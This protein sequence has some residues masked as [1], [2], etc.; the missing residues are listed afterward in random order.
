M[1]NAIIRL[2]LN[3]RMLVAAMAALVLVLGGLAIKNLPVDVFPDLN[4]P[5]VTIMTEAPGMAP[6]EVEN[7]ISLPLETNLNGLPG[8]E[9][10]RS[11][12][13]IG[14]GVVYVE[15]AWGTDIYR[16]RQLV[17]E[18]IS[19]VQERMPAGI[20]PV[21]APVSSIMGQIM[22]IAVAAKPDTLTPTE[23]RTLADWQLRPRLMAIPG[24][25][26]VI[27]IG[28]GVRQYQIQLDGTA[29]QRYQLNPDDVAEGL[30][31]LARNTTGGFVNAGGKEQLVRNMS[32]AASS[33][34][35]ENT[36]VGLHLGQPVLL[37]Q[38]AL[39][40]ET[41]RVKRGDG[42]FNG[43]PAVIMT[44][45]KQPGADT[46]ALT[47]A[48][49][50]AV[51]E[52]AP[53][54]PAGVVIN[55]EVFKQATFIETAISNV[56]KSLEHGTVLVAL[57]LL[58][59][60][61]NLR[62]TAITLTAIPLSFLVA[63]LVFWALG[64]S[65]NTMTLGGLAIAIGEL[66]DDA[67]V[68]VENVFRRL[69]ENRLL[70]KPLPTLTVVFRA[71]AEVRNSIVLAT[72]IVVLVFLPLFSLTGMEGR[73]FMP[74]GVAYI[75]ALLASLLVSLTVTPVLCSWLLAK[76][77][78]NEHHDT[79]LV[80]HLK[81]LNSRVLGFSVAKPWLIS[82]LV[83]AALLGTATLIPQIGRDFLPK[84]NEGTAM[85]SLIATPGIALEESN[86]LGQQAEQVLL[87]IPEVKL[88]SRRVGRA[89]LDEHAE[90]VNV[91]E[92]D[93]DFKEGGRPR[94][95]V[96]ED[97]REKLE[98]LGVGVAVGQPISHRIDH[99]MSGVMAQI[100]I[101]V[102]GP[103]LGQLRATAGQIERV[104]KDVPGL[105]DVRVE[106]QRLV[107]Q[108]KVHFLRDE[109]ARYGVSVGELAKTLEMAF[110]GQHLGTLL[111]RG[112][113]T[114]VVLRFGENAAVTLESMK[115]TPVR[116]LPDGTTVRLQDVADVYE[117]QGPNQINRENGKRRIVVSANATTD[118]ASAVEEI[119]RR[120]AAEVKLPPGTFVVYD[121]QYE[122]QQRASQHMLLLGLAALAGIAL[123]LYSNFR[124]F[125]LMGLV[126]ACIPL[127]LM[128]GVV[129]V[130]L[131]GLTFNMASLVGFITLCGIASRNGI[132]LISHYLHLIREEGETFSRSM[133]VRGANERLVPVLMTAATAIIGLLPLA[134]SVDVPGREILQPVALV[135]VSGLISSTLIS[136]LLMPA[137]FYKFGAKAAQLPPRVKDL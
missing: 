97:I 130:Y 73:L 109:A 122:S 82:G 47:K 89:E 96:L 134:L 131:T 34:D 33:E 111:E 13:G 102:F 38:V 94:A 21:L 52:L 60:L 75:V 118:I 17:A 65:V 112:Q 16:N 42:G 93:V 35:M 110:N 61:M 124:S 128:G 100:A 117:T 31:H 126:M 120:I 114:D 71:S 74:L 25:A 19:Q 92:L 54:L 127:A 45:E 46:V 95:V 37:K 115:N 129:G 11:S 30:G 69:R 23:L 132:M 67:I 10:V 79:W 14:L 32:A 136:L 106:Q 137:L 59:F 70:A 4:R 85:I 44:I 80:R 86:K 101:K 12:S 72:G 135:I 62:T 113:A 103:E 39:V 104:I 125:V 1:L 68:D 49:Q 81:N 56:M 57:V 116:L 7:L 55:A 58:I 28:G 9:R 22:A 8:V 63:A 133:I 36:V 2:A 66:V 107:P 15:F 40:K 64:L 18:K 41:A 98:P 78:L 119:Q 5:V 51:A 105:V 43:K 53:S 99:M 26:Q 108:I 48:V 50:A 24:V 123:L 121:G 87:G 90:G 6:E 91:S 3:N 27:N 83:G 20:T 29:L 84:F 76:G 88:V 77:K